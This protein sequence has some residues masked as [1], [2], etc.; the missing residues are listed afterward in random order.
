M[1]TSRPP[2]PCAGSGEA[3]GGGREGTRAADRRTRPSLRAPSRSVDPS[4][5]H[6][7]CRPVTSLAATTRLR[8]PSLT[9]RAW[10]SIGIGFPPSRTG[11]GSA[12][13]ENKMKI[14]QEG[15]LEPLVQ[16]L[17]SKDTE[18]LREVTAALCNLSVS[19]EN[20]FEICKSGAVP[21][22][23]FHMQSEDISIAAQAAACLANLC[24]I[25]ENQV[26]VSREGGIRPAILSMRS[27]FVEVQREAG[28]LLANLCA[29]TA[30]REPI[31][32]AG[33]H[34]L[35][36][37][38][39]LSQDVASQRVGALG[40]GNLCTH[41]SLRL[42]MMQSGA[43][44]PLCSLARSEDIE[45]EIQRYAVLALANLAISADN[46]ESFIEEGML[47]LLISL[48]NAPDPEV[49]GR[50]GH[51]GRPCRLKPTSPSD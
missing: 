37:S 48:S 21:P 49:S 2:P 41:E 47:T 29:S 12:S 1:S 3:V 28:R 30:Y 42:T 10:S 24:E 15:G 18:I 22:L 23:V 8:V 51:S 5:I 19:D 14:V 35:L 45:L 20:K 38:Y 16:L 4:G 44:E 27:R 26:V 36:I 34:Q 33:G 25:P 7:W 39:L 17:P 32:D 40:V 31:I 43:L 13:D 9:L 46:H 6:G 50:C 11:A